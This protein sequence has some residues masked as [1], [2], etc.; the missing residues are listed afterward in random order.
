[1]DLVD[2]IFGHKKTDS[3]FIKYDALL[4]E[5]LIGTHHGVGIDLQM[6]GQLPYRGHLLVDGPFTEQDMLIDVVCY[7]QVY[8]VVAL[9]IHVIPPFPSVYNKRQTITGRSRQGNR[10]Q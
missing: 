1:M 7:L 5:V 3:T 2:G 8:R 9:E 4:L 10:L 6:R